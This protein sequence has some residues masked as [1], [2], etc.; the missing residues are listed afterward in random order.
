MILIDSNPVHGYAICN[1][2]IITKYTAGTMGLTMWAFS[3]IQQQI[4]YCKTEHFYTK[5]K[6]HNTKMNDT[7][8]F[9]NEKKF[10]AQ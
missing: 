8:E 10:T 6:M 3:I 9:Y 7:N 1:I 5:K 2:Y 4:L